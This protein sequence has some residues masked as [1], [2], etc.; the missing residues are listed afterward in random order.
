MVEIGTGLQKS[1]DE[2]S[3]AH[4]DGGARGREDGRTLKCRSHSLRS[5][6]FFLLNARSMSS[7]SPSCVELNGIIC[8]V[9]CEK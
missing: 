3:D 6:A 9:M 1:V 8:F 7:R 5:S 4:G 2:L